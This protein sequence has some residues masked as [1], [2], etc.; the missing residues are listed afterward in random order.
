M[1]S[2]TVTTDSKYRLAADQ[3][4][5]IRT[6]PPHAM[7]LKEG[8]AYLSIS[9]KKLRMLIQAGRVKHARLGAKI[10]IRREYLDELLTAA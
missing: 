2:P 9:P 8:A 4:A 5:V 10:V 7:T 6:N 3:A 1:N